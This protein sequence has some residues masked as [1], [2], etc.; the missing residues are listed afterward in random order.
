MRLLDRALLQELPKLLRREARVLSDSPHRECIDRIVARDGKN[1][2]T[3]GHDD[4]F[5]FANHFEASLLKCPNCLKV[6]NS[7]YLG[8]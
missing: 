7:R 1:A 6:W 5:A 2:P 3:V 8:H 4:V